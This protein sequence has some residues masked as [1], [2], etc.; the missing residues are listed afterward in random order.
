MSFILVYVVYH[1]GGPM[2][3]SDVY[4]FVTYPHGTSWSP[5]IALFGD[6][7]NENAQS[8][9]RLQKDTQRGMYDA[10]FHVGENRL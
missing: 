4:F 1:V 6:M 9:A 7:G 2:G 8:L 5:R 10:I 3:W